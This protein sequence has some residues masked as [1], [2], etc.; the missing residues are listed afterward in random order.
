MSLD[1]ECRRRKLSW[2]TKIDIILTTQSQIL[3]L[4]N[5]SHNFDHEPKIVL[6]ASFDAT[7]SAKS[8][9]STLNSRLSKSL[10]NLFVS[11]ER[12][13][14]SCRFENKQFTS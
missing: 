13:P 14:L 6:F 1:S 3:L 11:L 5:V 9:T 10:R 12:L 7:T 8:E 4:K 2:K